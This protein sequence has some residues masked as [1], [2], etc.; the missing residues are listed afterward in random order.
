MKGYLDAGPYDDG[1][2][3]VERSFSV[4]PDSNVN[5]EVNF[6]LWSEN[7]SAVNQWPVVAYAGLNNPEE[8]LDFQIIGRTNDVAGWKQYIYQTTLKTDS[9]G[10]LWVAFGF[11]ATWEVART[12]YLDLVNVTVSP[13]L[14]LSKS[15]DKASASLGDTLTYTITYRNGTVQSNNAKI[16]DQIPSGTTYVSNSAKLNGVAKTDVQ[17]SDEYYFDS[18]NKKAVWNLGNLLSGASGNVSFQ[19]R[20]Q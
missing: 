6:Y 19:V 4:P 5:V 18:A 8:E 2:I 17:D 10:N 7:Y 1:T 20:I 13:S 14:T 3:W 12:Y 16:A 15:V 11:H 9:T